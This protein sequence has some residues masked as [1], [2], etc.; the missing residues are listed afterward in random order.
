MATTTRVIDPELKARVIRDVLD[1]SEQVLYLQR[2]AQAKSLDAL[3]KIH[4]QYEGPNGVAEKLNEL[5]IRVEEECRRRAPGSLEQR[6]AQEVETDLDNSGGIPIKHVAAAEPAKPSSSTG[7]PTRPAAATP[8]NR[9][10]PRSSP[11]PAPAPAPKPEPAAKPAPSRGRPA[12]LKGQRD[13][14]RILAYVGEHG[15]C[16][17][18][19]IA[20]ALGI[21]T[22]SIGSFT[23]Q[24]LGEGKLVDRKTGRARYFR[25][26]GAPVAEPTPPPA[27]PAPKPPVPSSNGHA[28]VGA[29]PRSAYTQEQL[30]GIIDASREEVTRMFDRLEALVKLG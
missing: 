10:S 23:S 25:L 8:R 15:E 30:L 19:E 21:S 18:Q 12:V 13:R 24:L 14:E 4:R 9:P 22:G 26:P 27:K 3:A 17:Q 20:R 5:Q 28:L 6:L 1:R 16:R 7:P 11:P 29:K 2:F